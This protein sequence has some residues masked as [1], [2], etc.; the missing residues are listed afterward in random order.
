MAMAVKRFESQAS[1]AYES[2]RDMILS[3]KLAPGERLAI[4]ELAAQLGTSNGPVR[5]AL[6][7]LSNERLVTGGSGLEWSVVKPTRE[8]IDGAL[9]VREALEA[10]SARL[11]AENATAQELEH[12]KLLAEQLDNSITL[13]QG[14]VRSVLTAELDERYHQDIAA[15]SGSQ[16]LCEEIS[17]WGVV[18]SWARLY[19]GV[20]RSQSESHV[21][22]TQ[23]IATGDLDFAE[24]QMRRHVRYPWDDIK[25]LDEEI[26][27]LKP[28]V[29][30]DAA[31]TPPARTGALGKAETS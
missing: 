24:R 29:Q 3:C 28:V 31:G 10:Q 23:A 7:Q 16:Q 19:I 14:K 21:E 25:W 20:K 17:R 30:A 27:P 12:L 26:E 13:E 9:I 11:C 18:M 8:M 6:L 4:R 5:D 22:L 15:V 1:R 2:L